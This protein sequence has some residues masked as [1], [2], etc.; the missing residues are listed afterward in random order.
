MANPVRARDRKEELPPEVDELR[1]EVEL[2][3]RGARDK[4]APLCD[5]LAHFM[6]LQGRLIRIA[7][8]AIDQLHLDNRY[9]TFDVEATRRERDFLQ[10][11]LEELEGE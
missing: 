3:P 6:Q 10:Q 2:L 9:L 4:L 11:T 1:S 7:Q 8:D 5:R